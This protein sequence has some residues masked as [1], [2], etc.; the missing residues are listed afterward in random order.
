VNSTDNQKSCNVIGIELRGDIST[1]I[2]TDQEETRIEGYEDAISS[3]EIVYYLSDAEQ[4]NGIKAIL[5]EVDSYGG[6]PVAG[7]EIAFKIKSSTKPVVAFIRGSGLSAA[8]W[9]ISSS[10]QIFA[11]RNSEVGSIGVTMSYLDNVKKNEKEGLTFVPISVGKYKDAGNPDKSLTEEEKSIFM[12]DT[13]IMHENFIEDVSVNRNIPIE[14]VRLFA[15]G[16]SVLGNR[17]KELGLIDEIG[18]YD[19]A[20]DYIK[21]I[22]KEEVS[23]CW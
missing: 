11:S 5:I 22:I 18:G 16:S 23:V 21:E 14:K 19:D 6:Y 20:V 8:Y 17:A 1:Y 3:E 10:D 4:D 13:K 2:P 7:E 9:A 12:R 15:D